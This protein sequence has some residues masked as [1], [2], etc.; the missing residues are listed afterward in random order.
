MKAFKISKKEMGWDE[1]RVVAYENLQELTKNENIE[2]CEVEELCEVEPACL[3][4]DDYYIVGED[5][6]VSGDYIFEDGRII[7][8][9]SHS[10]AGM[11]QGDLDIERTNK[12]C[13]ESGDMEFKDWEFDL[14]VG[15][16][17][18]GNNW[19]IVVIVK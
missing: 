14:L 12:I 4:M 9:E 5:D 19:E 18:D 16:F 10:G 2:N 3:G 11:F 6:S 7:G 1:N 15:S 8:D 17:W 13:L